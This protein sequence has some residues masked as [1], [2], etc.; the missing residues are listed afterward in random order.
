ME[1]ILGI[2][3]VSFDAD[4]TLWDFQ[5]VMRHALHHVLMELQRLDPESADALNIEKMIT[6]RNEVA[7]KLRGKVTNLEE[8]RLEA[9][10]ETL[11]GIGRPNESLAEHLNQVYLKHRFEDVELFDDVLLRP[12]QNVPVRRLLSRLGRGETRP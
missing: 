7:K 1:R 4:G 6:I 12:R 2:K 9:F 10:R 8:I 5:E 11:A 3:A